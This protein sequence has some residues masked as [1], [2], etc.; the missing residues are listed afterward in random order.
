MANPLRTLFSSTTVMST[1]MPASSNNINEGE[2]YT[3]YGKRLCG[4]VTGN[5]MSLGAFLT[6]VYQTERQRQVNNEQQQQKLKNDLQQ[7]LL[8]AQN[9]E[10]VNQATISRVN[11]QIDFVKDEINELNDKLAEAKRK[12]GEQNK[13]A[14]IKFVIGSLILVIMTIY[15]FI[16]YSS[17]FYSAFLLSAKKLI[18]S[19]AANLLGMAVFNSHAVAWAYEDGFGSLCFILTGPVIFM[20]LGYVLHYFMEQDGAVKWLKAGALLFITFAFDCIL[21][22]KIGE[23][24]YDVTRAA[25]WTE[26][27]SYSFALAVK[28]INT[29]AVIFL[30]FIV[31][32]IWGIV[33]GMV[34][35]AY[36]DLRSNKKE[37]NAIMGKLSQAKIKLSDYKQQIPQLDATDKNLKIQ[38]ANLNAQISKG[39]YIDKGLVKTAL[40]DFY[41]GWVSLMLPL[42]CT[43]DEQSQAQK[44]YDTSIT[45]FF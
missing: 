39:C 30:G 26:M 5:V 3:N 33:F 21:A 15:L 25:S 41:A 12:D 2:T 38:I 44:I 11:A 13:M 19:D 36:G 24:L 14:R 29:Y 16:F 20:G 31:Y 9:S 22:Y 7:K 43:T 17:T 45:K 42:G 10:Q 18:E 8:V 40:A 35:T 4:L 1:Q 28:D 6:K 34:M 23:L 27:P 32:F 37:I